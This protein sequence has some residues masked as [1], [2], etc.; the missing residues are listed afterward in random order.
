MSPTELDITMFMFRFGYF[1]IFY[2]SYRKV[3]LVYFIIELVIELKIIK[4][5]INF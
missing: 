5:I 2:F 1:F 4:I 3:W